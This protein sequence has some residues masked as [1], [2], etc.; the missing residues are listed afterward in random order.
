MSNEAVKANT[1]NARGVIEWTYYAYILLI[2][3]WIAAWLLKIR[4][5]P[6]I[7]WL[8]TSAGAFVYWTTAKL[9]LWILPALWLLRIS[10]RRLREVFQFSHWRSWLAWGAGIGF[11]IAL[12]G[13]VPKYLR[14]ALLLPTELSFPLGNVLVI[15]PVFEEFL[16][17]G[18]IL[19]NLRQGY[20]FATANIVSALLFV[21]LHLPGWYFMGTLRE[22]MAK[23]V[24]GAVSIF[25]LGL[26]FGYAARKSNSVIA[27]MLAHGLNNLA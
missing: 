7:A 10:D 2:S 11:L 21:G 5:D 1:S 26:L 15:A 17:R 3:A 18:A 12:T 6:N 14:G 25:I 19:G 22:N 16:M 27:A 9:V 20:S 24:G 4:L 8:A 13:F 23:P